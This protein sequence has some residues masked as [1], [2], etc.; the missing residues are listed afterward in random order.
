M[1][2]NEPD[3]D[4]RKHDPWGSGNHNSGKKDKGPPDLD[5]AINDTLRKLSGMFGGKS[6]GSGG[7]SNNNPNNNS[8]NN[9]GN[10]T[11]GGVGRGLFGGVIVIIGLIWAGSG[12]YTVNEQERGVVLR[13][14]R[15]LDGVV[16]PGLRWNPPFIDEVTKINVTRIYDQRFTGTMLT[17][18]DN[19]VDITMTVQYQITNARNYYL[20]VEAPEVSLIEAAESAIRH[21]V[22]GSAMNTVITNGRE[23]LAQDARERLQRYL[24]NYGTGI[25]VSQVNIAQSLPPRQVRAAFDDVIKAREDNQ[26]SQNEARA[27]ANRVVPLARGNALRQS[28]NANAYRQQ[29]VAQAQG[30]AQRFEQLLVEY[31]KAP[32]VMRERLYIDTLQDILSNASKVLVDVQGSNN[33]MYLPLDQLLQ[34]AR[35]PP[36]DVPSITVTPQTQGTTITPNSPTRPAPVRGATR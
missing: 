32:Q 26:S 13:L 12:V 33:M 20:R 29:V 9:N 25:S 8:N 22:G 36:T 21:V 31:Q 27:Y 3:G 6:G 14:G 30:E 34:N 35:R 2:W 23:V 18:D 10:N 19:I 15:A 17:Q 4:D 28:E 1:A 7:N 11:G 16:E 24:D 5:A